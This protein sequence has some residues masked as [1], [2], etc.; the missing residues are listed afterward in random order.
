MLVIIIEEHTFSSDLLTSEGDTG[1][2]LPEGLPEG[3]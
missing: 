1:V 3:K 2:Y